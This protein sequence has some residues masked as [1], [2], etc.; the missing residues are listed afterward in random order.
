MFYKHALSSGLGSSEIG[1]IDNILVNFGIF[2]CH[3]CIALHMSVST[4]LGMLVGQSVSTHLMQLKN[5]VR[6]AL[7]AANL[8]CR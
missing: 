4:S 1:K 2:F 5:Q 6:F 3:T 8:V 7:E